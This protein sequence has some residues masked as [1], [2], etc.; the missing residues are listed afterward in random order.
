MI[1]SVGELPCDKIF[2]LVHGNNLVYNTCW[3]DPRL[4]KA[5]LDIGPED[6]LLVITSGGC[7]A[8]SYALASPRS[9]H[10]VDANPRQN[11]LLELKIAGI[12]TLDYAAFFQMFG[13]GHLPEIGAVYRDKLRGEL[14]D[15]ARNYWDSRIE[16][17]F[18][19][20]E[21]FYFRGTSGYVARRINAL[22]GENESFRQTL[23]KLFD[24]VDLREQ[25]QLW[26][27]QVRE[28]LWS[29][30][31]RLI[32][33]R[34]A[35][36][37]ML[38]IPRAGRRQLEERYPGGVVRF[39]QDALDAVFGEL[40]IR[41]NYFWRVYATGNYTQSCCPEYLEEENFYALKAGLVD[42]IFPHTATIERFLRHYAGTISRFALLDHM[43][44]LCDKFYGALSSEWSAI[45][46][47]AA[48]TTRIIWRS[49]G[50]STDYVNTLPIVH[51]GKRRNLGDLLTYH[52]EE[53]ARLHRR[54][55]VHT[56]GSFSIA[57]LVPLPR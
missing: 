32:L 41:D 11:A 16:R 18:A 49:G 10:A 2:S 50:L 57:D 14:T 42:R 3:E 6:D 19:R 20:R 54:D 38:G 36:L 23:D 4:D 1:V 35:T 56:Y 8:L 47:K 46:E 21:S 17:C 13:R 22:L 9:V 12:R 53:A 27:A 31:L 40:P 28:E 30:V 34:D 55:R 29:R 39:V 26:Y 5:A 51:A 52:P 15:M 37:S 44:W 43:D 45:V 33:D 7:N 48:R 24:A 25:R